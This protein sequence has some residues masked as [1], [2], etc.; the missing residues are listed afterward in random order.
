M[1]KHELETK[2]IFAE[3]GKRKYKFLMSIFKFVN[4][5]EFEFGFA[6]LS[7]LI[8]FV[9][10]PLVRPLFLRTTHTTIQRIPVGSSSTVACL[11]KHFYTQESL[12]GGDGILV[13]FSAI[14]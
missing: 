12:H 6:F 10:P 2:L 1:S 8:C 14:S 4:K 5:P 9:I 3:I 13:H 11:F 7:I